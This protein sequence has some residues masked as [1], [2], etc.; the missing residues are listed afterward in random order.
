[1]IELADVLENVKELIKEI[2]KYQL[3]NFNK[4]LEVEWKSTENDLVTN[5]DKNS[6]M[7]IISFI[8]ENY[9]SHA[10][11]AEE[12]G[13]VDNNSEYR[14]IID[15]LDGTN[16]FAHGFPVFS[17]SI[18]LEYENDIVLAVVY[19]PLLGELFYAIKGEGSFLNGKPINV[20]TNQDLKHALLATG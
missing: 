5:V 8:K 18:A 19:N 2:G 16:N 10:I 9:P 17:I 1:M 20:S 7:K 6:E 4:T 14:W 3:D 15:P 11:K 12:G 13:N